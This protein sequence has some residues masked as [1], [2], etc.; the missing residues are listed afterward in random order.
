M[1]EIFN[2]YLEITEDQN[3]RNVISG[4]KDFMRRARNI[5]EHSDILTAIFDTYLGVT[6]NKEEKIAISEFKKYL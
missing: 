2:A 6:S 1:Y 3:E 5:S 4:V